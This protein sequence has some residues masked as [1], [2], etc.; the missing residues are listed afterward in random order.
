M[1]KRDSSL[2]AKMPSGTPTK[3]NIKLVALP[4]SDILLSFVFPE[5]N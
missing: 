1:I 4:N 2:M 3:V 5:V